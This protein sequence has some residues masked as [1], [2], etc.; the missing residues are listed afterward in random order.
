MVEIVK[1]LGKLL[2]NLKKYGKAH[3][4]VADITKHEDAKR[5]VEEAVG[6]LGGL[7]ALVYVTGPPKPG[8]SKNFP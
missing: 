5:L 3:G 1:A 7:D 4:I 6:F 2:K 8:F